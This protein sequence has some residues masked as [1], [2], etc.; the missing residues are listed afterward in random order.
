MK[1]RSCVF[2]ALVLAAIFSS[3]ASPQ[4]ASA[5]ASA[6]TLTFYTLTAPHAAFGAPMQYQITLTNT[7]TTSVT[8]TDEVD[9]IDPSNTTTVLLK[10][11]PT[12]APGQVL[13]TPGTFTTSTYSSKTGNFSLHGFTLDS[14]GHMVMTKTIMLNVTSVPAN[15]VYGSIGGRGPDTAALGYTYDFSTVVAN[16]ST[17]TMSLQTQVIMTLTDGT[18]TTIKPG[19][20]TSYNPGT[21]I[22]TPI[23]VS[24]TQFSAK[25]G[26]YMVTVNVLDS[27]GNILSTDVHGFTR[28]ILPVGFFAPVF[29]DS[30]PGGIDIPRNPPTLPPNCGVGIADFNSGNSGAAVADY[31]KDGYEDIFVAG[32]AGDNHLWHNNHGNATF[33]DNASI[34][35]IPLTAAASVSGASFADIDNDG[36]PDLLLLGGPQAQPILLHNNQNG[37]FT[38]IT[39]TS[40]LVEAVPL[41]NFSATWGDYDNDGFLD[42]VIVAHADCSGKNSGVHLYHNNQNKTFTEVTSYLGNVKTNGR[43]LTAVF[44]DYNQDGRVDLYVGNDQGANYGANVLWRNDG[45]DGNGGWIFTDVSSSSTAG[46]AMAAMGIAIGDYN[47]DGQF[48]IYLS[49]FSSLPNPSSNILLQGSSSGV[50]LQ[51]QGDQQ[52]GAHAKR[53]TVPL[54]AGGQAPSVTWGTAFYDFNNDGW[55][56][57]YLAGS[58]AGCTGTGCSPVNTTLLVNLK[59]AFL[60][61]GNLAGLYGSAKAGVAPTAVFLDYNKDGWMDVFQAPTNPPGLMGGVIHLFT[62]KPGS[63][64]NHWLQVQLVGTVSNRDA[65][66]A[67]LTASVASATLLRTVVNGATYQGNST[68]IQQFGLGTATQVDSLTINWP[69]GMVQTLTNIPS[70]QRMV[71]TEP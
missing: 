17:T 52:G 61:L 64:T 3:V 50:F 31:D 57:L 11:T 18:T 5:Q 21:N 8:L 37:T 6:V 70:N 14:T 33:T 62:N 13:G 34:A 41:N 66:G 44:V 26:T 48:D 19:A 30:G 2:A 7:G 27:G 58:G 29:T 45:S 1:S 12:L 65:V 55:E 63:N 47:R 46:V 42:L 68:L 32:E 25:S 22:I 10:T 60:D 51:N 4:V 56:D 24:T 71:I 16:L 39:S 53:G 49:N 43:G 20:L 35:G 59:G 9:L 69:S 36:Y 67:R 40:G 38:D 28:T 54:L 15:G 23:T